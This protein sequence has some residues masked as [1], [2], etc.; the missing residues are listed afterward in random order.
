MGMPNIWQLAKSDYLKLVPILGLAFYIAFIPHINYPYPIHIDEWVHMAYSKAMLQAGD[1]TF[2]FPFSGQ[3]TMSLGSNL[4]SGFHLF[5]GVFQQISG[6]SWV[7]IFRYFP[8]IVFIITVLSVFVLARRQG[9]GW[10]A[11]LLTCLIPTTVGIMGP[12]FLVPVAMGLLFFP[13]SLFLVFNFKTVWSYLVL[14]LFTVFLLSIHATTA[15]GL[16]IVLT[17]Y[18]LLNLKGNF[19]HSLGITLALAVPFVALFPWIFA[20]ILDVGKGLFAPVVHSS[21]IQLPHLILTYGYLPILFC[22]LGT[23]LLAIRGGKKDYGLIL[24]LLALL[25]MLVTY[26]TFHYGFEPL[27]TRGLLYMMVIMSVVAGA[28][29]MGVKNFRLP[30]K[31]G[32]WIRASFITQNVGR[33]LCLALIAVMLAISIPDRLNT[34]YYLMIDKAD[35]EAF[36]WITENID[37][38]YQK[39]ILDPWKATAFTA[40]TGRPVY[41]RIHMGPLA[42]DNEAYAFLR[43]GS[44]NTTF[45]SENEISIVYTRVHDGRQNVEFSSDNPDL[46]EVRKNIYILKERGEEILER[47]FAPLLPTLPYLPTPD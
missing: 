36:V 44:A 33:F 46:V 23:C 14:F 7:T 1:T 3:S 19:K 10:E 11:A 13:L 31:L 29:L 5:W 30:I 25:L 34:P 27:Y 12:A 8:G 40:I 9:F 38:D 15:V 41:T 35:Y 21:D 26:F 28:G 20:K 32:A 17:P 37:Q 2:I 22:L 24:G 43:G 42:K 16:V 6:I 47:G 18:I 4:E 39:V 45:L